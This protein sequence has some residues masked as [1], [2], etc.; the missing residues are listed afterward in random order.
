TGNVV[1]GN[2]ASMERPEVTILGDNVN[3]AERLCSQA[4]GGQVFIS[5]K[6]INYVVDEYITENIGELTLKG[7]QEK[8][9]TYNLIY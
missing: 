4:K 8:I 6:T 3:I 1:Y 5:E 9:T 2:I 7:K